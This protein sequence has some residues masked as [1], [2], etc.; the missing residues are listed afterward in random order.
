MSAAAVTAYLVGL[1]LCYFGGLQ[2]GITVKFIK[3]M[4]SST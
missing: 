1:V 2:W 3:D 4:G